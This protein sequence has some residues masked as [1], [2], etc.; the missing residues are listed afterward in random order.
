MCSKWDNVQQVCHCC[1]TGWFKTPPLPVHYPL[2]AACVSRWKDRNRF[3]TISEGTGSRQQAPWRSNFKKKKEQK[4]V[5]LFHRE[6]L[7]RTLKSP[8]PSVLTTLPPSSLELVHG[9]TWFSVKR[10][11]HVR[12]TSETLTDNEGKGLTCMNLYF[13]SLC[14]M[15]G[16]ITDRKGFFF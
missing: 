10:K 8:R 7:L 5:F 1:D 2:Q 12:A 6:K 13:S 11:I 15:M 14:M 9:E 4:L 16:R 3:I